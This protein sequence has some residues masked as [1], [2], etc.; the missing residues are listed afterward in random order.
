MQGVKATP[1]FFRGDIISYMSLSFLKPRLPNVLITLVVL[2]LPILREHAQLPTGGYVVVR[3]RPLFVFVDYLQTNKT[4]NY[5]PFFLMVVLSLVVYIAASIVVAI[6][7]KLLKK[8]G[9]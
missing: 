2:L 3:Y 6:A 9:K 8:K 4:N 1:A 7:S 5:Y